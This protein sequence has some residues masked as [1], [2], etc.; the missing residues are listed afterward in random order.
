MLIWTYFAV[1]TLLFSFGYPVEVSRDIIERILSHVNNIKEDVNKLNTEVE[2]Y[3]QVEEPEIASPGH[4]TT[5]TLEND[6]I[7]TPSK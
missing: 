5:R 2:T 4:N 1:F 7:R 3:L 6:E